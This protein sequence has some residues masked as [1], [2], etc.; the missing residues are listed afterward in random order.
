MVMYDDKF[1]LAVEWNGPLW[2][3]KQGWWGNME[4]G[5]KVWDGPQHIRCNNSVGESVTRIVVFHQV[6]QRIQR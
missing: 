6:S 5:D 3:R 1:Q 4:E 2:K